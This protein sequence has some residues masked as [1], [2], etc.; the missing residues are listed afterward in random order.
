MNNFYV[1]LVELYERNG[2]EVQSSLSPAHFPGYN[3]ADIHFTYILQ[4]G[5]RMCKGGG[6]SIVELM[7]LQC[8][9][10][11]VKPKNIFVIGNAFGWTTLALGLMSKDS[12]V[13]AI[14]MCRDPRKSWVLKSLMIWASRLRQKLPL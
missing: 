9:T 14:D 8:V 3:L 7:F 2:F 5:K 1:E 13:L 6:L 10:S 12:K 4:N 11:I